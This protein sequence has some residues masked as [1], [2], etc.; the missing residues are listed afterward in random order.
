MKPEELRQELESIATAL[1]ITIRYEKGDFHGG[2]CI[3][4]D[5]RMIVINRKLTLQRKVSVLARSLAEFGTDSV[6]IKP[7]VRQFI[8]DE[9]ARAAASR[10][11]KEEQ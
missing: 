6:F 7:A 2:F 4:R 10:Y 8:E 3:L 11:E 9:M 5:E 1:G